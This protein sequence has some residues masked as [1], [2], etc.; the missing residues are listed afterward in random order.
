MLSHSLSTSFQR[1]ISVLIANI[2]K[3]PQLHMFIWVWVYVPHPL[4]KKKDTNNCQHKINC[5]FLKI[6]YATAPVGITG[7]TKSN[8]YTIISSKITSFRRRIIIQFLALAALDNGCPHR[9]LRKPKGVPLLSRNFFNIDVTAIHVCFLGPCLRPKA[10]DL[11]NQQSMGTAWWGNQY[12]LSL[13]PN[14]TMHYNYK[15]RQAKSFFLVFLYSISCLPLPQTHLPVV[16]T[17]I[18]NCNIWHYCSLLD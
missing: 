7:V 9:I 15:K 4:R 10:V 13:G 3:M 17:Q 1:P 14:F 8:K 16:A 12:P 6:F 11:L 5:T 2:L 18:V